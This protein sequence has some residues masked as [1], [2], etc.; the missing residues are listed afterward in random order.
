MLLYIIIILIYIV[1]IIIIEIF[2]NFNINNI[3]LNNKIKTNEDFK[4]I[5]INDLD[6]LK[7][8]EIH[9]NYYL[10]NFKGK[11]YYYHEFN[12]SDNVIGFYELNNKFNLLNKKTFYN[13]I[14]PINIKIINIRNEKINIYI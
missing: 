8:I 7:K 3:F 5:S 4:I 13:F 10:D 11:F 12:E 9:D 1:T 14:N 6:K 2:S